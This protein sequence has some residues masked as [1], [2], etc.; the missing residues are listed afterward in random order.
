MPV[1]PRSSLFWFAFL[2]RAL[3]IVVLWG[4]LK[5]NEKERMA[6]TFSYIFYI[7]PILLVLYIHTPF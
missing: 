2:P 6:V 5:S 4:K 3:V 7:V 1:A